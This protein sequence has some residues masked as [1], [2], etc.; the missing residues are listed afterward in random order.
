MRWN[1]DNA[2]RMLLIRAAVLSNNFHDL[3]QLAA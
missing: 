2:N 3:W 1:A